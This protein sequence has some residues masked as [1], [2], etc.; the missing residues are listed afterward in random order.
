MIFRSLILIFFSFSI[1]KF[2]FASGTGLLSVEE[3]LLIKTKYTKL[4]QE[5]GFEIVR[6]PASISAYSNRG[7]ARLFL[8]DFVGA[9]NDYEK[10]IELKPELEISHWRLGIAY[11]YLSEFGKAARQFEIYHQ[12]DDVDRENGIWRFMSQFQESG[13]DKAREGLLTYNRDDRPP[14]PW[15]YEMFKGRIKPVEVFK[16]I[17]AA[18]F[19]SAY[20]IRVLFH[21]NLYV[22][23]FL[24]LT[25]G[26]T[27]ETLRYLAAAT[28]NSYGRSSQTFMWQVARLHYFRVF[29]SPTIPVI[30]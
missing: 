15:L 30:K 19:P 28:S 16:K 3:L 27:Q 11:F 13:L 9:K 10:M 20:E 12:F 1:G 2:L 14:Y 7:D 6:N 4:A 22:G 25:Q 8:G 21:A 29:S 23:I 18:G 5:S 24:E 17:K 26:P